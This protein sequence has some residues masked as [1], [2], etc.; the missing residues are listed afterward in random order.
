MSVESAATAQD[1]DFG[2]RGLCYS[3]DEGDAVD[4]FSEEDDDWRPEYG[5]W[6]G[7]R[8]D[9]TKKLNAA[10]SMSSGAS[11]VQQQ[12]NDSAAT[13]KSL[14]VSNEC[15]TWRRSGGRKK[16]TFHLFLPCCEGL[17]AAHA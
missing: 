12:R 5:D 14:H 1:Q 6:Q 7:E 3:S 8:K 16:T 13:N 4:S 15:K 17:E 9:F 10:R 2:G 11:N